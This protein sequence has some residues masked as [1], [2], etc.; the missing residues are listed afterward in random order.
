MG[1]KKDRKNKKEAMALEQSG[2]AIMEAAGA[3]GQ[4]NG[5]PP[6]DSQEPKAKL[7]RKDFEKALEPLQVELVKL[8]GG[9]KYTGWKICVVF[10]GRDTAGK[11]GII[12]RITERT[13]PRVFKVVALG[14]PTEREKSQMY[15]QPYIQYMP[16]G[17][18]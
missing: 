15:L 6:E 4:S 18:A 12:K 14:A 3:S 13:S 17:G 2:V 16:A 11:G 10:E 7:S 1:K 9:V 8:Q 5:N